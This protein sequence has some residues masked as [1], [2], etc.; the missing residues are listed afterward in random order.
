M[1]E[2]KLGDIVLDTYPEGFI[3]WVIDNN[4][5][6]KE[7]DRTEDGHRQFQIVEVPKI[8]G[9]EKREFI[10]NLKMTPLDFLKAIGKLGVTYQMVKEIMEANPEVEMEMK[11]CQN[12]YRKHPMLEQFA[13]QFNITSE[14]LDNIF[15][16]AN[17]MEV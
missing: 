6:V 2:Y 14:Q 10:L 12:V 7:L 17:G 8:S 9:E 5:T 3:D 15:K 1:S 11:F 16:E 13:T 4:Y